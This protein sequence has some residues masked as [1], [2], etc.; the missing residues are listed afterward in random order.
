[1]LKPYQFLSYFSRIVCHCKISNSID[2]LATTNHSP[3]KSLRIMYFDTLM[4]YIDHCLQCQMPHSTMPCYN[5][6]MIFLNY[7]Q[8]FDSYGYIHSY[9]ADW[10]ECW[11]K[12]DIKIFIFRACI[13]AYVS[14]FHQIQKFEE[15]MNFKREIMLNLTFR[16]FRFQSILLL[17][18][19]T[20]SKP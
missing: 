4:G 18:L 3:L 5:I 19:Y 9:R 11:L 2:F 6:T 1:M 8:C 20:N 13:W 7:L 12:Q 17:L 16:S 10:V 14:G 15:V